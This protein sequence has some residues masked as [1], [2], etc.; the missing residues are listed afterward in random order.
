MTTNPSYQPEA[1]P[2]HLSISLDTFP[3]RSSGRSPS[4][5]TFQ[6]DPS[7]FAEVRDPW[8]SMAEKE[9]EEE[10]VIDHCRDLS[11]IDFS[12]ENGYLNDR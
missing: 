1:L 9:G 2:Y 11:S 7:H 4:R 12:C 10:D 8:Q 3:N 5:V 6:D